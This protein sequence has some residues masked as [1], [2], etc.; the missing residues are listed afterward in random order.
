[1]RPLIADQVASWKSYF[2]RSET[3]AHE[4]TSFLIIARANKDSEFFVVDGNHRVTAL[5]QLDAKY[6]PQVFIL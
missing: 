4:K 6:A 3:W 2:E 1:M 5:Q